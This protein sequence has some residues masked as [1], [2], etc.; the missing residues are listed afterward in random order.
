M[1]V[2]TVLNLNKLTCL[3]SAIWANVSWHLGNRCALCGLELRYCVGMVSLHLRHLSLCIEQS[4]LYY[5]LMFLYL[6][7]KRR[8]L[9]VLRELNKSSK[10]LADFGNSLKC[11][12]NGNRVKML[13]EKLNGRS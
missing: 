8:C 3:P 9:C 5:K 4:R 6:L 12:H 13:N 2:R 10:Q 11:R 7:D 1:W